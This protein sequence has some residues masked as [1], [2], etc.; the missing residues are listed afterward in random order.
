MS[1]L[2]RDVAHALPLRWAA[3]TANALVERCDRRLESPIAWNVAVIA[4]LGL[5]AA[6][7]L[8]HRPWLDEYQAVQIAV[9]A[10]DLATLLD[11]LRYEGH[12]PLWYLLLRG[13]AHTMPPL[14]TLPIAALVFA[15]IAQGCILA[16]S[17]FTRAERLLIG[18]S[19]FVLFDFLTLSRSLAMGVAVML[20]TM[21]IWRRRAAWLAIALLPFCDFLFGVLSG[22]LVLLRWRERRLFWPGVALWLA[23]G[24][25]ATWSVLPAADAQP[26]LLLK[27]FPLDTLIWLSHVGTVALPFQGGIHPEWNQGPFPLQGLVWAPFLWFAWVETRSDKFGRLLLF[28]FIALTYLFSVAVYPLAIRHL[29]L[30]ALLLVVLTW[31]RRE[32]GEAPGAAFRLWL[33]IVAVCGLV[34][35]ALN[36]V[37]PFDTAREAAREIDRLGLADEH[38]MVFPDSRGQG[39][40]ALTGIEFE[41]PQLE[42][43]Q[44]FI[45]WNFQ[46]TLLKPGPMTAYLTQEVRRHGGFY[47]LTEF[48]MTAVP[49]NVLML[50]GHVDAGYD[51]QAFYFY[52][53]GPNAP[54]RPVNL[55]PCV[56]GRRP[57]D[58][59]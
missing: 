49:T 51:G 19:E 30:I 38:W 37:W 58:R 4:L 50:V 18:A 42:C 55:P 35:A 31:R 43:M 5:Q 1:T 45:R 10:P 54:K 3:G 28:G 32:A 17:P 52:R 6:L 8:T 39:I 20:L 56:P 21:A 46:P 26:A 33:T 24:A 9:E 2:L 22:V 15:A 12:P 34:T 41:R 13:L 27:G 47:L 57:F 40:T 11:W 44:S 48:P 29:M 53:V 16:S 7:I 23:C 59:L 14:E 25:A 36:F